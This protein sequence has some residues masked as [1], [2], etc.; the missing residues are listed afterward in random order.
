M[1]V[2]GDRG[3]T[4]DAQR[5]H[6]YVDL[7]MTYAQMGYETGTLPEPLLRDMLG[8]VFRGEPGRRYWASAQGSWHSRASERRRDRRFVRVVED[9]YRR[10]IAEGPPVAG[11]TRTAPA[12]AV[13]TSSSSAAE[14]G[15]GLTRRRSRLAAAL[16]TATAGGLA[17][18]V[19]RRKRRKAFSSE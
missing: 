5:R 17:L 7:M 8:G 13:Q 11:P 2:A 15:P 18:A 14:P 9:E 6:V 19:A 12:P 4:A 16:A 10:A 1:L 3:E